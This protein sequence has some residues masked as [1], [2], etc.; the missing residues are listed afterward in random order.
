MTGW[1]YCMA[2]GGGGTV[3]LRGGGTAWLVWVP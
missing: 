2:R 1:G 3:W